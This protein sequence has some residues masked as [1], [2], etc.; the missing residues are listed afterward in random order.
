MPDASAA[1][2][3]VLDLHRPVT[4]YQRARDTSGSYERADILDLDLDQVEGFSICEHCAVLEGGAEGTYGS[5][6]TYLT[7]ISPCATAR[8]AGVTS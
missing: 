4:R 8:A 7:A 2:A 5:R 6:D 1:L 3:A